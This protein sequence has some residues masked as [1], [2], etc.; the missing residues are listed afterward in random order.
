MHGRR[1]GFGECP[2]SPPAVVLPGSFFV[3]A[4]CRTQQKMEWTRKDSIW[5]W[6]ASVSGM[7]NRA[8]R[9]MLWRWLPILARMRDDGPFECRL[10]IGFLC[11]HPCLRHHQTNSKFHVGSTFCLQSQH[12]GLKWSFAAKE[13][14]MIQRRY[15]N[16]FMR[17]VPSVCV[18]VCVLEFVVRL[19][20]RCLHFTCHVFMRNSWELQQHD[21]KDF[22]AQV[23]V[24]RSSLGHRFLTLPKNGL[25]M[26]HIHL[27][28]MVLFGISGYKQIRTVPECKHP[29]YYLT[30]LIRLGIAQHTTCSGSTTQGWRRSSSKQSLLPKANHLRFCNQEG[31]VC[32]W[33]IHHTA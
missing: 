22:F 27:Y 31:T 13:I 28:G 15:G 6:L 17:F 12:V 1:G 3:R 8:S 29:S 16:S 33:I 5:W 30:T 18:C 4:L 11:S 20:F 26:W 25:M 23:Q 9:L 10:V 21:C 14:T 19:L 2:T 24:A 32:S 7:F